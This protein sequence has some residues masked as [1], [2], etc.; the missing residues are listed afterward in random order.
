MPWA[1]LIRL[2]TRLAATLFVWRVATARRGA[3]RTAGGPPLHT[4]STATRAGRLGPR[5]A[6]GTLR[7]GATLGWHAAAAAT[8]TVAAAVLVTGGTTLTVLGPRWLGAL[9]LGIA[10][11]AI[12]AAFLDARAAY[13]V[14]AARRRRRRDQRVIREL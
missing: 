7:E 2:L 13:A 1:L 10:V 11:A 3:Y 14:V 12:V 6:I 5:G 4:Q 9:L 8:F